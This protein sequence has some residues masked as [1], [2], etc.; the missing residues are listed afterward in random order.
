MKRE[1][2]NY[3]WVLKAVWFRG[4]LVRK[5]VL[6]WVEVLRKVL[7]KRMYIYI[8]FIIWKRNRKL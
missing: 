5:R 8:Y 7:I 2:Y 6:E 3:E 1:M 4:N